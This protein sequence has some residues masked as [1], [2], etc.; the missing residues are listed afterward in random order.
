MTI[1][2]RYGYIYIFCC[3]FSRWLRDSVNFL[4]HVFAPRWVGAPL[5]RVPI[6][7]GKTGQSAEGATATTPI[8]NYHILGKQ[9][10]ITPRILGA[11]LG[12]L[13]QIP[14]R[15]IVTLT[16]T[17]PNTRTTQAM[18]TAP[19]VESGSGIMTSG[20]SSGMYGNR[21]PQGIAQ[22]WGPEPLQEH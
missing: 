19:V 4:L 11:G 7:T 10:T 2:N 22:E 8:S 18:R 6:M 16:T 3:C 17:A 5:S 21:R 15:T 1:S 20:I 14:K 9:I 13:S 12:I